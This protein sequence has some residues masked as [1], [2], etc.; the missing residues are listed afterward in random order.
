[1]GEFYFFLIKMDKLNIKIIKGY[2][3]GSWM[4]PGRMLYEV[5]SETPLKYPLGHGL[6]ESILI[7]DANVKMYSLWYE[8][9]G[10]DGFVGLQKYLLRLYSAGYSDRT[11]IKHLYDEGFPEFEKNLI[12]NFIS[13]YKR[14]PNSKKMYE[15]IALAKEK[16]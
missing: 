7:E 13:M 8:S 3:E 14:S 12:D 6:D 11:K 5:I 4:S 1:M 9:V 16:D 2:S 10:D 15:M